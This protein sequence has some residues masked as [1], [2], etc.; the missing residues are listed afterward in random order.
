MNLKLQQEHR[1]CLKCGHV[2]QPTDAGPDYACPKCSA[3]YAKMEALH[4][5]REDAAEEEA[6]ATRNIERRAALDERFD[7]EQA[8]R[9]AADHS[10]Y[11]AAH[12]VYLLMVLP[13]AIT[14]AV[15]VAIA[16]KMHRPAE[17]TWL[18]DHFR[19]QVRTFGW[20]MAW[21]ALA[22]VSLVVSLV[23]MS[24]VVLLREP[25]PLG[26]MTKG[27]HF[28]VVFGA[29]AVL[30]LVYRVG[31]GWYRLSQREAP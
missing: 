10:A 30:T 29:L 7:R 13:F 15:A 22:A 14:Q 4:Q 5:A 8:Q 11:T 31:K 12:A 27:M 19:W 21:G 6:I 20:M 25:G 2:R 9:D 3:V 1:E 26:A 16:F 28:V 24:S 18:N 17:D 23:A